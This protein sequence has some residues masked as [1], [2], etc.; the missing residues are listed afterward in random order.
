M[1]VSFLTSSA[2]DIDPSPVHLTISPSNSLVPLGITADT[3]LKAAVGVNREVAQT[4]LENGEDRG[5]AVSQVNR[6]IAE[7]PRTTQV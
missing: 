3:A 4:F 2:P 1:K 5:K 7:L 6:L